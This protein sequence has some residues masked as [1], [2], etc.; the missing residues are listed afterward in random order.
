MSK[1]ILASNS[2]ARKQMLLNAGYQFDVVPA[3]ID[4]R[5]IEKDMIDEDHSFETIAQILADNKALSVSGKLNNNYIIGS[6]QILIFDNQIISKA[7]TKDIAI[8]RLKKFRGKTHHLISTVSVAQNGEV[9]FQHVETATLTMHDFNDDF[10]LRY[11]DLADDILTS[12]VGSYAL[13]SHGAQLFDHIEGDY[14]SILGMPLLPLI[15]FLRN[16]GIGL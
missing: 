10:L 3:N 7:M 12:C 8:D 4:E 11:A 15:G 14:F 13:E 6:D 16:Q 2:A 5:S 9:I 1:L